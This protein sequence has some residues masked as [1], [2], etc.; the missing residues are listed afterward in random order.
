MLKIKK[1]KK[2]ED[3][4]IRVSFFCASNAKRDFLVNQ[5]ASHP[6]ETGL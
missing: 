6:L 2:K 1:N 5:F 4:V 3:D